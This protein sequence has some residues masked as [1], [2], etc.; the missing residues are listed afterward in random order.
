MGEYIIIKKGTFERLFKEFSEDYIGSKMHF[1]R[2]D[3]QI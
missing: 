2:G 1:W 3:G